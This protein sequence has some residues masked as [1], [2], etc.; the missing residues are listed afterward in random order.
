[1]K[2]GKLSEHNRGWIIGHFEQ[3][4]LRTT[5]FEVAVQTHKK[6]E[7]WPAHYHKVATEY[8]VLISGRMNVCDTDLVAGDTFIIEPNEVAAPIFYED[9]TIMCVKVPSV[10][11]DKYLV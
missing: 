1:M 5:D 2:T 11:G 4:L 8:N 10:P 3:S 9:C 6:G 7:H